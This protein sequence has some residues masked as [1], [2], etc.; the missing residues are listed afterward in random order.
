MLGCYMA[1]GAAVALALG[2]G[3]WLIGGETLRTVAVILASSVAVALIVA[4][5]AFP[6][7]AYRRKDPTGEKTIIHEGT[8]T[9]KERVLDG[10]AIEAPK[11]YQLPAAP[12]NGGAYPELLRAA[13][14]AGLLAR[15]SQAA[16]PDPE[17][18]D[19]QALDGEWGGD[20]SA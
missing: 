1:A 8:V 12:Q 20:I 18:Q 4:A 7:R 15:D 19:L 5:S 6:I 2:L 11:L 17:G 14:Q 13:W 3:L 16:R 9:V 10:R